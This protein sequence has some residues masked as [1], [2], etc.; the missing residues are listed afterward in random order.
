MPKDFI[1]RADWAPQELRG[2]LARA[3]ELKNLLG[4]G[5][6]PQTL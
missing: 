5:Q 2:M 1:S 6:R 4:E 3:Q